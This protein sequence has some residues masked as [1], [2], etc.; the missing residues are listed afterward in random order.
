MTLS[1]SATG[2]TITSFAISTTTTKG[3]FGGVVSSVLSG[4][5]K[6]SDS[7]KTIPP[8]NSE[9]FKVISMF[10]GFGIAGFGGLIAMVFGV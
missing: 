3:S 2:S 9:I 7:S 6:K 8:F 4:A 10:V 5:T 1:V